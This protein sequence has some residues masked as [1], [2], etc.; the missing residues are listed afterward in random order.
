MVVVTR[1]LDCPILLYN[2]DGTLNHDAISD[3]TILELQ[4]C[5]HCECMVFTVTN[6]GAEDVIIGLDWLRKHNPDVDWDGG[7]LRLSR[8]P[9]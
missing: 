6:I 2:I 1:K 8:C 3:V 5:E 7:M 9:E 4:V